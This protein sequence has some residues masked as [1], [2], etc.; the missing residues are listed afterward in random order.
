MMGAGVPFGA[1]QRLLPEWIPLSFFAIA[2][3]CLP[4]GWFF[5]FMQADAIVGFRGGFGPVLSTLHTF[6]IGVVL[7]T[8]FGA[9]MQMLPVATGAAMNKPLGVI[10]LLVLLFCGALLTLGGFAHYH[11]VLT[12]IGALT[13][14][15]AALLYAGMLVRLLLKSES[16]KL[17]RNHVLIGA[18]CLL[19]AATL[20]TAMIWDWANYIEFTMPDA[21]L[22]HAGLAVYGFMGLIVLGFSRVMV[23]MLSVS[24][25]TND[26]LAIIGLL[27][28]LAALLLWVGGFFKTACALALV[29]AL[30]HV[31]EMSTILKGRIR[32]RLGPEWL[33]I[34]FSWVMLPLSLILA[35]I[36]QNSENTL[37]VT[38]LSVLIAVLGWLV[39]FIIG[40]L[41]RIIPF[42]L[43][44]QI[45]RQTGMPE[46]PT[47][48]AEEKLLKIIGPLHIGAVFFC[49]F[50]VVT[51]IPL[52]LKL[53]SLTGM[54]SGIS[55]FIFLIIAIK[56]KRLSLE[57]MKR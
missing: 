12:S 5:L 17:V 50:A 27:V 24:D 51:D 34:R 16:L 19:L 23:P 25:K 9:S 29:A 21:R 53:G 14:S 46:L 3:T 41:Q 38:Q 20:G 57:K 47:R 2:L 40:I 4:A 36:A 56:R 52:L 22:A 55:L 44:M 28:A 15:L 54:I 18:L 8:A 11:R 31:F 35:E 13:L 42:L 10:I 33:V 45:A 6:T 49:G 30:I 39:S 48:L 26:K 7:T 37:N 43:S 32:K 1:E